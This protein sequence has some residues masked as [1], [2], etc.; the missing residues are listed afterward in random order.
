MACVMLRGFALHATTM[1][2]LYPPLTREGMSSKS[3]KRTYE[4]T[5]SVMGEGGGQRRG[6][7]YERA[8]NV[9]GE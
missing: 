4:R 3:S 5:E 9:V 2:G 1:K 8:E 7:V 6:G